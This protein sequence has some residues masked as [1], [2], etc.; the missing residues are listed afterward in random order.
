MHHGRHSRTSCKRKENLTW[1][2]IM[3]RW[4]WKRRSLKLKFQPRLLNSVRWRWKRKRPQKIQNLLIFSRFFPHWLAPRREITPIS[5][6]QIQLDIEAQSLRRQIRH[7]SI[8]R[9]TKRRL[10]W[11]KCK[12]NG[13]ISHIWQERVAASTSRNTLI[14]TQNWKRRAS[15]LTG[16]LL[17]RWGRPC[18]YLSKSKKKLKLLKVRSQ[19]TSTLVGWWGIR[20][21]QVPA[22]AISF[23]RKNPL[24]SDSLLRKGSCQID[25]RKSR[26]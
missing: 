14:R 5:R 2:A 12:V 3:L 24:R 26:P 22:G 4:S 13:Q 19:A 9:T 11:Q 25:S 23:Q 21:T 1:Q 7:L 10:S 16:Y 6:N 18:R 17:N 20:E 15:L 8:T